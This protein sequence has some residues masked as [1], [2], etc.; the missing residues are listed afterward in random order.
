MNYLLGSFYFIFG[1]LI[2]SFL[3][4]LILRLP[5]K[6][7]FIYTRSKCPSCSKAISWYEN[8]PV[9]SF[10]AL[11]GKC[12]GCGMR[13]SWR[14]PA[15]ELL[16]GILSLL[17]APSDFNPHNLYFYAFYFSTICVFVC[18]IFIDLKHHLIPNFLNGYLAAIF[19]AYS[20]Y[21]YSWK[22]W[23]LGG[24]LGF[25]FPF[26]VMYGFYLAKGK[27]GL[28]GGDIKLYAALGIL[29]GPFGIIQNI[30]ISCFVGSIIG[31]TLM[32]TKKL[33]KGQAMPFGP[34]IIITSIIQLYFPDFFNRL[35]GLFFPAL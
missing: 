9:L 35:I 5:L 15:V 7:D 32:L 10:I 13:I 34:S 22:F 30:F 12:S 20:I 28:G 1:L 21:H 14:Y 6:E 33:S 11:K 8:F 16:I 19:L 25:V 4:V 2:G 17:L 18:I 27:V 31:I 23:L 3:N 24:F 26:S 29:F